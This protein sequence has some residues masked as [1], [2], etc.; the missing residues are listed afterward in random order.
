MDHADCIVRHLAT[1]GGRDPDSQVLHSGYAA[2]R[3]L[4]NLQ[5]E[6]MNLHAN[7]E[8]VL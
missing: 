4:A 7:G 6:I 1:R 5:I 2:W 8:R 3:A